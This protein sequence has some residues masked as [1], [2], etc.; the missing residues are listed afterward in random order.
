MKSSY[1]YLRWLVPA[2]LFLLCAIACRNSAKSSAT[3]SDTTNQNIMH[4]PQ[5]SDATN[6][7]LADT[8][9]QKQDTSKRIKD[10]AH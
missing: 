8:A 2:G 3:T 1:R 7:S 9:Y 5:N 6:P 4:V 10:S